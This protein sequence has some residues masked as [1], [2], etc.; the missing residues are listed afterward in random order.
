MNIAV[1]TPFD[2]A[3]Y[4]AYLQAYCLKA[5]LENMGHTVIHLRTREEAYIR[6][7]Y[8]KKKPVSKRD[9]VFPWKFRRKVAFGKRKLEL[10]LKDQAEFQV[11]NPEE[12]DPDLYIL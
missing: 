5:V 1:I 4:G 3:N 10:F 8:Y 9:K 6:N 2:S 12:C 11:M 7:L